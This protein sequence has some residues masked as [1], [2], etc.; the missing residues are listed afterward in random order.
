MEEYGQGVP[1]LERSQAAMIVNKKDRIAV[2]TALFQE[3]VMYA[4]KD[5]VLTKHPDLDVPNLH[6]IKLLQSMKSKEYVKERFSWQYYYWFLTNEGIEFL[7]EYLHLPADV[8]PATLKKATRPPTRPGAEDRPRRYEDRPRGPGDRE[9]YRGGPRRDDGEKKVGPE[10]DYQPGFVGAGAG[11][12]F[13]R[14]AGGEGRGFGG[15]RGGFGRGR[16]EARE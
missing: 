3:G 13:G 2:Y 7:R 14:G 16:G 5:Y 12:G 15:G 11:R 4:K 1:A 8:V 9:G 6:V 10:G